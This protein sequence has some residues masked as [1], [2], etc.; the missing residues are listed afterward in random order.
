MCASQADDGTAEV[1]GAV[2][3]A[4]ETLVAGIVGGC[5][6]DLVGGCGVIVPLA[7]DEGCRCKRGWRR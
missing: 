3:C 5:N 7:L 1:G 4:D 2:D 6:D